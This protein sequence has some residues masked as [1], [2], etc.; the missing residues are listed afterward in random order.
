MDQEKDE[1]KE[2]QSCCPDDSCSSAGQESKEQLASSCGPCSQS[3][4]GKCILTS[5]A[6]T[7][8]F[9]VVILAAVGVAAMSVLKKNRIG[10]GARTIGGQQTDSAFANRCG[11]SLDSLASLNEVAADK[12]FVFVLLPGAKEEETRKA[13][14]VI[15][16]TSKI[17]SEKGTRVEIFTKQR[18]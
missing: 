9:L 5:K 3:G 13:V 14:A 8:I 17:I 16:E 7:V 2:G 15:E 1:K 11:T 18:C 12:D 4:A 10:S 6:R